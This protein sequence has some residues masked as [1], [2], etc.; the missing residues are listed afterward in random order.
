MLDLRLQRRPNI[1]PTRI[2]VLCSLGLYDTSVNSARV[3]CK[4]PWAIIPV[5]YLIHTWI[6]IIEQKYIL[7]TMAECWGGVP[8]VGSALGLSWG[9]TSWL[10]GHI[11]P[12]L[13][14]HISPILHG[15][16]HQLVFGL[17]SRVTDCWIRASFDFSSPALA[18]QCHVSYFTNCIYNYYVYTRSLTH[19]L[20][21]FGAGFVYIILI[22]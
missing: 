21:C 16:F 17:C 2:N 1:K 15:Y 19:F 9:N 13:H 3:S 5:K 18:L 12:I 20:L 6:Y 11:S 10:C 22:H 7:Q 14:G 4:S 8:D